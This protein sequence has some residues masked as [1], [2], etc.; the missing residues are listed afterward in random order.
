MSF[1]LSGYSTALFATWYF[2][3]DLGILFDC[4][5]GCVAG[6]LQKSGKAR[7][8]F[9]SHADRDHLAGLLQFCQLNNRKEYPK[10]FYPADC[11]SFPALHAFSANFDPH[12]EKGDW[13]GIKDKE[14]IAIAKDIFVTAIRNNHVPAPGDRHKSLGYLVE[15][16]KRKLK[17]DYA[18]LPGREIASLRKTLGENEI[19][20]E[21]REKLL[22]Y[23][24]DTPIENETWWDNTDI[25]IH[26]ATFIDRADMNSEDPRSNKHSLLEDVIAMAARIHINHLVL[27]HF[28]PRYDDESIIAAIQRL[29]THYSLHCNVHAVLPGKTYKNIFDNKVYPGS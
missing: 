20:Y 15:R 14:Q 11:G 26:E 18:G 2:A 19:A 1:K 9:M 4:G 3:E 22:A 27:G 17:E 7:H 23:S 8:I 24:G 13:Q 10:L 28:S 5:D 16:T 12:I 29:C 6:L 21:V 25:L